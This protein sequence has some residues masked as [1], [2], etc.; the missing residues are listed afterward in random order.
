MPPRRSPRLSRGAKTA[1]EMKR[2]ATTYNPTMINTV[3]DDLEDFAFVGGTDDDYVNPMTFQEAWHH[4]DPMEANKWRDAIRKE[5]RDMISKGVWRNM[6]KGGV[7]TDRRL[8]GSKWVFKKKRNGVYRA[9]LCALGYSQIP[10]VDH[11]DNYAPVITDVTFRIL[12]VLALMNEWECEIVD[13][14]TAFLYGEL[15]EEIFMK[16]PT[17]L[18]EFMSEEGREEYSDEE[19]FML[20]KSMYGLVQAA[21]QFY[22][23]MIDVMTKKMGFSKCLS[24]QCLLMRRDMNGVVYVGLYVDDNLCCGD[25]LAIEAF[26]REIREHF[27]TKEEGKM[28]EYV[29]CQVKRDDQNMW[30]HQTELIKKIEKHFGTEVDKMRDYETPAGHLDNVT[31]PAKDDPA[32]DDKRQSRF[33]S[34]IGMLLYLV[35]FSRPD[36]SNCVRELSKV[37]SRANDG[38]FKAL[39]RT[40]KFV[41]RTRRRWLK[42]EKVR[43]TN[44]KMRWSIKAYGD[45][46]WGGDKNTRKSVTGYCVYL[47]MNLVAWKSRSQK[48]VTLSSSEAEYVAMSELCTEIVFIKSIL[49]FMGVDV[50]LPIV[51]Y[52]DNVGAVFLAHNPKTSMRTKHV[53]IRYHH[54]REYVVDGVIMIKFVK[55]EE[56][57][58]DI[59][60][61]NT[62]RETF[63]RH[64]EKFMASKTQ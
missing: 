44:G 7:P 59:F 62:N 15:D 31:I 20:V 42:Y 45:S 11:Q 56:N 34:G 29:G 1:R 18:N 55:S 30:L 5:F 24:D 64:Q 27:N 39:L 3:I 37:N 10:G 35:K 17:G 16:I 13:V 36:L 46:D 63:M 8:I 58:A 57:D 53:D 9:R 43:M 33:R 48:N 50:E 41:L 51:V 47:N 54:V 23:K 21:R 4:P 28:D 60:T 19:C 61:K 25:K 38:H 22:K 40:I 26:K 49:E 32:L 12:M 2:I 14:E 6:K 52:C